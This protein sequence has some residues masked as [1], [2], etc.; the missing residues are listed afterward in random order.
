MPVIALVLCYIL[1]VATHTEVAVPA[2]IVEMN[3]GVA[4]STVVGTIIVLV[5]TLPDFGSFVHNRKHALIAAGVTFLVAYPLLYWRVQRR[6]PLV[7]RILLGAMAVFGA[8]LP[9]ALLLIFACVTGNAG[10]MFRGT[11]VVSTLLTRFPKWQITV[12]LGILSAIVGSMD[13]MAWFIP[14]LL[15]PGIATPP[16]AGIYIADF[17]FIAVMAIKSQC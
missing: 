9:A 1:Y 11:L 10:N 4:V 7:V 8:V 5:A 15:F 14:F 13:I 17:S 2:A 12:A 16:V 6:A 3:T